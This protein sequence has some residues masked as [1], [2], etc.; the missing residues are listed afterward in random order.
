MSAPGSE[1][2]ATPPL[3]PNGSTRPRVCVAGAVFADAGVLAAT[4]PIDAKELE[5]L[6]DEHGGSICVGV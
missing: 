2:F 3:V 4:V 1:L 5:E 6:E